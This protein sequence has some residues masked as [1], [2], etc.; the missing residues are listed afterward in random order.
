MVVL[1]AMFD[2]NLL[3]AE[4]TNENQTRVQMDVVWLKFVD[5]SRI[6]GQIV[7]VIADHHGHFDAAPVSLS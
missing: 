3:V 4:G 5:K 1:L 7:I 2:P 6:A